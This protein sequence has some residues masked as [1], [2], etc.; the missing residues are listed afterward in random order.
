[1]KILLP[2]IL[3]FLL[4]FCSYAQVIE[5]FEPTKKISGSKKIHLTDSL[6]QQL[7]ES[8]SLKFLNPATMYRIQEAQAMIKNLRNPKWI[9]QRID[10]LSEQQLNT[11]LTFL[12]TKGVN[13]KEYKYKNLVPMDTVGPPRVILEKK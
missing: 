1:M 3:L 5:K 10:D 12:E 7:V 4:S 2:A 13:L 9:S 8:D 6:K 11:I